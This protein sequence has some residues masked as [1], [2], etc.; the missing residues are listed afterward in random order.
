MT[1]EEQKLWDEEH[2]DWGR[3]PDLTTPC[4]QCNYRQSECICWENEDEE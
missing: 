1:N 2:R 3:E 4:P